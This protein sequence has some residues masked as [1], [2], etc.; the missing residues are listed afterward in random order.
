MSVDVLERGDV[1]RKEKQPGKVAAEGETWTA[2]RLPAEVKAAVEEIAEREE[3]SVSFV[4]R[5]L[6]LKALEDYQERGGRL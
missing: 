2:V 6:V 5:R 3:R 4:L 1:P